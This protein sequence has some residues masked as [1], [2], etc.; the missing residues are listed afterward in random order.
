MD[1]N[2]RVKIHGKDLVPVIGELSTRKVTEAITKL[3]GAKS[4]VNFT[5]LDKIAEETAP[6]LPWRP[7]VLCTGCPHRAS[8]YAIKV[9]SRRVAKDYGK[10][11]V[12]IYPGDISCSTLSYIPPLEIPYT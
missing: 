11:V 5:Q 6:L 7:P 4:P 2:I 1:A 3:T 8:Q 9:A 12:P 10:D